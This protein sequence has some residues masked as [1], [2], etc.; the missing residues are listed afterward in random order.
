M[1]VNGAG[2]QGLNMFAPAAPAKSLSKGSV[3][4]KAAVPFKGSAPREAA[5]PREDDSDFESSLDQ[6]M[7]PG[8]LPAFTAPK[9]GDGP[10]REPATPS[11]G[12]QAGETP[13][14]AN[15]NMQVED[16]ANSLTRRVVW[17]E[18]LR[19]MGDLGVS[20]EDVMA[21]F[22]KLSEEDLTA[23][24]EESVNQLALALG[25][26]DQKTLLAKQ[27]F[28]EL[29][30][31]TKSKSLGEEYDTSKHQISLAL[32]SERNLQ[33]KTLAK[34]I[35][36]LE[37]DF[38]LKNRPQM[39]PGVNPAVA[40]QMA[41]MGSP[42]AMKIEDA[43]FEQA[44]KTSATPGLEIPEGMNPRFQLGTEP[45]QI[46]SDLPMATAESATPSEMM[47]KLQDQGLTPAQAKAV[48]TKWNEIQNQKTQNGA[49]VM[50]LALAPQEAISTTP[51]QQTHGMGHAQTT[52]AQ[53]DMNALAGMISQPVTVTNVATKTAAAPAVAAGAAIGA[54]KAALGGA[55]ESAS[56]AD[57]DS[58][59]ESADANLL[60]MGGVGE[61]NLNGT[62]GADKA[63]FLGKL[64]S[65]QMSQPVTA[66]EAVQQAKLM[67]KEGGGEMK[68][69][70]SPE[71]MGE[72]AMR[73]QVE[74]GKV[75]VHMITESDEA[76][77]LLERTMGDLKAGLTQNNL[78]VDSI[79]VDTA[80]NL[81]KQLE[82]Q[83]HESQRQMAH[84]TLEQFRQDQQGWRRSF[85]ET[86]SA[87][88]YASQGD[89]RRDVNAPSASSSK[90]SGSRRLDL[91][92]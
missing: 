71:G 4:T 78:H 30:Q 48:M 12:P 16:H 35:D 73:V 47:A 46:E 68:V 87:R 85:F 11:H 18:F 59:E 21:A 86:A 10:I 88:P 27:Y 62:Q 44:P 58:G 61:K 19:K 66:G 38:F 22:S 1:N 39:M 28:S 33:R 79:K 90:R 9:L 41:A 70:L 57:D 69:T 5:A 40:A 80:T 63:E 72:I 31:K 52:G 29:I 56:K 45:T 49:E 65:P 13:K 43:G 89:A 15:L 84:Q 77:K 34:S 24:P 83:Y 75:N 53:V 17:N 20:A 55:S 37:R 14:N 67:I 74:N 3:A 25:L 36:H 50:P 76:K 64:H 6:A 42:A 92:A 91:V 2:P 82:Q 7:S 51:A 8:G 32:L 81:G 60:A 26:N 54:M 23:P